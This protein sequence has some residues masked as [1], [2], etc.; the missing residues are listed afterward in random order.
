MLSWALDAKRA[1]SLLRS[2][3][4]DARLAHAPGLRCRLSVA[5]P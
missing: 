1:P 5:Q 2:P 4:A 3:D